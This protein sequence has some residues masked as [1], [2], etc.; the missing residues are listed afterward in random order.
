MT[1]LADMLCIRIRNRI[2]SLDLDLGKAKG[3]TK[4]KFVPQAHALKLPF[5]EGMWAILG[6]GKYVTQ[7]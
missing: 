3:P 2:V 1:S 7:V 6:P 5:S 4:G